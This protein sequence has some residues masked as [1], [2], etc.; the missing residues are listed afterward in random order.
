[1][2]R[3]RV[4]PPTYFFISII[5]MALLHFFVPI[6]TFVQYPWTLLGIVPFAAGVTLNLLA[7]SAFKKTQTTVK[8]FETSASF[9][10]TGVFRISRN[11]MYLGM[12]LILCGLATFMGTITPLIIILIFA[13]LMEMVFVR[14]EERM[15]E[16]QFGL[17]WDTYRNKVRKW[18]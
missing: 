2:I 8:P 1:M 17:A 10:T 16:H 3:K 18:F 4:L 14:T 6:S 13:I 9:I 11:P 5:T 7:D 12:V 15:L